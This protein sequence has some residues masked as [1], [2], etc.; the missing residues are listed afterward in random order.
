MLV[1]AVGPSMTVNGMPVAGR[2]DD[3]VLELHDHNG[4]LMATNDDWRTNSN[5]AAI[6]ATTLAPLDDRESALLQTLTPGAYTAILRGKND[7]SGIGLVEVYEVGGSSEAKLGNLSTRGFVETGDNVLIGG[8]IA[9]DDFSGLTTMVVRAVGPSL[10][11]RGVMNALQDPI[12]EAH[13]S[14]G[15]VVASNDNWMSDPDQQAQIEGYGLG[16]D[17]PRE[18][19]LVLAAAHGLRTVVVRGAGETSG[20]ALVEIYNVGAPSAVQ[21][22]RATKAEARKTSPGRIRR[23]GGSRRTAAR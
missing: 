19:A 21:A 3:T 10:A 6:E 5:A 11:M 12:L 23:Y 14:D 22:S 17:D 20:V 2:L 15:N 9:G 13:D 16:L 8:L 7:S 1:R 18:A 4:A